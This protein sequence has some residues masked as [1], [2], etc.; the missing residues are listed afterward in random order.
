MVTIKKSIVPFIQLYSNYYK[1]K[2]SDPVHNYS[3]PSEG[4]V[5]MK[6]EPRPL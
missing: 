1:P 2:L 4:K 5:I 6:V 3:I